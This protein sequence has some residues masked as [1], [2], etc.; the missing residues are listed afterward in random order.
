MWD[1][2]FTM[3]AA[4]RGAAAIKYNPMFVI[5]KHESLFPHYDLRLELS[6]GIL[7]S[8]VMPE[9]PFSG[10]S[11]RTD[12]IITVDH[13]IPWAY[14]EG[15]IHEGKYGKGTVLVWD[16]GKL[17]LVSFSPELEISG[18]KDFN[19]NS[20]AVFRLHGKKLRGDFILTY[21]RTENTHIYWDLKNPDGEDKTRV[22]RD[23]KHRSALTGV[24]MKDIRDETWKE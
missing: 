19:R 2:D 7:K 22:F 11:D 10:G 15:S 16:L 8:W 13:Y 21:N 20:S 18:Y 9:E 14:F 4:S 23:D 3:T 6:P 12:A 24:S 1:G 17:E 5:Q